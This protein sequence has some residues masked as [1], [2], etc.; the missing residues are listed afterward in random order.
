MQLRDDVRFLPD[1]DVERTALLAALTR[2][3]VL[4]VFDYRRYE[5]DKVAIAQLAQ[6]RG[7]RVV[8]FTDTWLTRQRTR[9]SRPAQPGVDTVALRQPRAD[10]RR[11]RN[12]GRGCSHGPW[13]RGAPAHA[14]R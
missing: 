12:R 8:V 3:D 4:V 2:R 1:R 9:R 7:G 10:T 13:R 5:D 11:R 6:E 14:A